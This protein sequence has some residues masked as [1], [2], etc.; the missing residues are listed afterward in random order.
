MHNVV[1]FLRDAVS[2][3]PAT[4]GCG[5]CYVFDQTTARAS[6]DALH[7]GVDWP[8]GATFT[9]PAEA[10]DSFL[11]RC[12]EVK[13]IDVGE[14][15][16]VLR[17][18]RYRSTI[19]R[20]FEEPTPMPVLPD[21]WYPVPA[22]FLE[23]IKVAKRF[24]DDTSTGARLWLTSVRLWRDRVTACSGKVAIDISLPGLDLDKPKLLG[25]TALD[26][27]T[28]QGIPD[29]YGMD[30]ST[31]SFRYDDGRWVRC[32]TVNAE[33]PEEIIQR[34]FSEKL[35][36][37]APVVID[38]NWRHA[39]ADAAALGDHSVGLTITGFKAVKDSITSEISLAVDVSTDHASWWS[40]KDLGTVI[41]VA[42]AW[43]PC[44]Y[45][46]PALFVGEG[47]RGAIVGVLR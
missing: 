24:T 11:A 40:T 23:A 17:S 44:N 33:M 8:S 25:K 13:S 18:G 29:E 47:F 46:E 4:T 21:E 2:R 27:L 16:V 5:N 39:H 20:R 10:V 1:K 26:F 14:T 32:Q 43:N 28:A 19:D 22:G 15:Q 37:E 9:L 38:D 35:G 3:G 45:P 7:A 36:T 42:S 12:D 34:L 30:R 41:E 6:N 31:I